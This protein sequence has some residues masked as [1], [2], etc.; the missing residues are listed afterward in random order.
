MSEPSS[1][2]VRLY[3]GWRRSR[4]IGLGN[5]S[6]TQIVVV[7]V[8]LLVPL[9]AVMVSGRLAAFLLVPAAVTS[10]L[11]MARWRGTPLV[12]AIVHTA[13][14][15]SGR[16]AGQHSLTSGVL[17]LHDQDHD[18]PGVLAPVVPI[19][20]EDGEGGRFGMAW[21]R[22][23]G[24]LTGTVLV[25]PISTALANRGAVD[26]W[27]GQ[28]HAWLARLGH[29]P[30]VAWVNVTVDTAPDPGSALEDYVAT[31]TDPN[32]P[33]PAREL[34]STLVRTSPAATAHVAPRLT[35]ALQELDVLLGTL[36]EPG[37]RTYFGH[38]EGHG[39]KMPDLIDGL[40]PD[41]TDRL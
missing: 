36:G 7:M 14:W 34:M 41:L 2:H 21:N 1:N 26:T 6:P 9:T 27:V 8:C 40:G 4:G 24:H 39:L 30:S 33:A 10:G 35:A 3:G 15:R 17:T 23:T 13:R 28:W 19:S 25:A 22:R 11:T 16:R 37:E 31:R 29:T 5:L 12:D 18:L 32:S 20:V 38:A